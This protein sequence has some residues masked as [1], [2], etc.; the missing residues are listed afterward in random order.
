MTAVRGNVLS[1]QVGNKPMVYFFRP[2][3]NNHANDRVRNEQA[4]DGVM[5]RSRAIVY[6]VLLK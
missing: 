3:G 6:R 5:A 1:N 2:C 4:T